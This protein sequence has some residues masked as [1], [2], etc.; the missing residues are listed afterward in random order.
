MPPRKTARKQAKGDSGSGDG[1]VVT[2]IRLTQRHWAALR[3]RALE[4]AILRGGGRPDASEALRGILDAW[5]R[6]QK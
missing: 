4:L 2:T 3:R 1:I 6:S 5:M